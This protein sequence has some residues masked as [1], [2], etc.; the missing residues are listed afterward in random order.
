MENSKTPKTDTSRIE[1][2]RER[3]RKLEQKTKEIINNDSI[4]IEKP[5]KQAEISLKKLNLLHNRNYLI[6]AIV[7]SIGLIA[8]NNYIFGLVSEALY[9]FRPLGM[10]GMHLASC[11]IVLILYTSDRRTGRILTILVGIT[12]VF[13]VS[14]VIIGIISGSISMI[15]VSKAGFYTLIGMFIAARFLDWQTSKRELA[16]FIA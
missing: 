4:I 16:K 8:A 7:A 5:D 12:S 6:I 14:S 15:A 3:A 11:A 2:L 10:V 1:E 13:V 9:W